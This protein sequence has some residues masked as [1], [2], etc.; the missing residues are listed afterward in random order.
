MTDWQ[1]IETAPNNTRAI[2]FDEKIGVI[3]DAFIYTNDGTAYYGYYNNKA[4]NV[5]DWQPIPEPPLK[6]EGKS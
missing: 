5:T 2:V 3:P 4:Y 1:P 6:I